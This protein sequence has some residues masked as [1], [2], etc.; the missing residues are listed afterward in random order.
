M[1][2]QVTA[3]KK[4]KAK[5][6]KAKPKAVKAAS[7]APQPVH[8]EQIGADYECAREVSPDPMEAETLQYDLIDADAEDLREDSGCESENYDAASMEAGCDVEAG[9][10]LESSPVALLVGSLDT[11][12]ALD[13]FKPTIKGCGGKKGGRRPGIVLT[14]DDDSW[15]V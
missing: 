7:G 1:F 4:K 11:S 9:N 8:D 5:A 6:V 13:F 15:I 10:S 12:P 3:P 14:F 2:S